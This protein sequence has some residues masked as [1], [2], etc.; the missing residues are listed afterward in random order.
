MSVKFRKNFRKGF[1]I[2]ELLVV[3][4]LMVIVMM[5]ITQFWRWIMPSITEMSARWQILR[6]NRIAMQNL[7]SDFGSAVG[8][9][10]VGTDRFLLCQD[11][12]DL[13]N[14]LAD[15]A[16]PDILVDYSIVNNKLLR[17]DLSTGM[18]SNIAECISNF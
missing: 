5:I 6:E 9:I 15:W 11:S 3:S 18:E 1:T 17:S 13:P 16:S 10:I 8:F 14:G 4:I 2:L 7:A 12:G